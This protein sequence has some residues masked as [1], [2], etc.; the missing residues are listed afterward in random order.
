MK[1]FSEFLAEQAERKYVAIVY[2]DASQKRLREWAI[3]S[4]FNLSVDFD[5]TPQDPKEFDFHTTVF[6]TTSTH[7]IPNQS[8]KFTVDDLEFVGFELLGPDKNIPVIR[9]KSSKLSKLRKSLE[10]DGFEDQWP[11]YKP[12]ISLSYDKEADYSF[13]ENLDLPK[14]KVTATKVEMKTGAV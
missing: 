7:D 6:Y 13:V 11:E 3:D 8:Y 1:G 12:H 10:E 5:G 2:D 9:V 14:F 4:G